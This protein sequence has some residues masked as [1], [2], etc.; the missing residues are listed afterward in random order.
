[1]ISL[2]RRTQHKRFKG[3]VQKK[4]KVMHALS[5]LRDYFKLRLR[6]QSS[7]RPLWVL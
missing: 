5:T 6:K 3:S 1:M 2:E 7:L 4:I